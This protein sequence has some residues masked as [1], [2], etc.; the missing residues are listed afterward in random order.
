MSTWN[1]LLNVEEIGTGEQ[2][3]SWGV[4]TNT[5]LA[6]TLSEAITGRATVTILAP[7]GP[8]QLTYTNSNASQG[9]RNLVLDVRSSGNLTGTSD[10]IVPNRNKQYI[11]ENNTTGTPTNQSI[12]VKTSAGTGVTIP[13]GKT[14]HVFCDGTNVRFADDYVDINGGFIDG[15]PIGAASASTGAFTVL[16]ATTGNI[17]TVNA[18]TGNID[19]IDVDTLNVG[20]QAGKATISYTTNAARTLTIPAISG[21]RT[22]ALL[23][24]AQTCSAAQTFSGTITSAAITM[25]DNSLTRPL[26]V[27][28]AVEGS[29][30]GNTGATRTLDL[31]VANFFSAT[32]NQACTFTFSNP[33]AS[34]KFGCFVLELTNGAAFNIT[35]PAS[36]DWPGGSA[37]SLTAS[38]KDQLVFTTRDAGTTWFGFLAGKDIR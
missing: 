32:L 24:E 37:P 2:A 29:A 7:I 10:V 28:Y 35:W 23:D 16:T 13:P 25:E 26:F 17:D 22:F 34:G 21:H 6:T 4:T 5:N 20:T 14:A 9:V 36:V 19:T 3:G 8:L 33:P 11:V 30:I 12:R 18:T 27:D 15:T 31:T 1:N 38:G